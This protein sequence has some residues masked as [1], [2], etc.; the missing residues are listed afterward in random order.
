M[1]D[2]EEIEE[3]ESDEERYTWAVKMI[4]RKEKN[5]K[6]KRKRGGCFLKVKGDDGDRGVGRKRVR[7]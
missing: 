5:N 1:A 6:G 2:M 7:V 4:G 3:T